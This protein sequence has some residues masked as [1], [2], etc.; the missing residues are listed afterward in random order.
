MNADPVETLDV[1]VIGAGLSGIGAAYYIQNAQPRLTYAVLESRD[2]IGGTWDLFRYPGVRS[3]SDMHTLGFSFLPWPEDKAF[4]DGDTIRTYIQTTAAECEIE[5]RIRFQT[6]MIAADWDTATALWTVTVEVGADRVRRDLCCRFLYLCTGY[7]D[8]AAGYQPNWPGTENFA[9][10]LVHPQHWPSDLDYAGK[11][12]VV[13]GSGATAVT[14]I[15]AMAPKAAHI[16]MLQRSPTYVVTR[17]SRDV[18]AGQLRRWLPAALAHSLTRWKNILTGLSFYIYAKRCPAKAKAAIVGFAKDQLGE[19]FDLSHFTPAYDPWDQRVCVAPDGD[20]FRTIRQGKASVVT[21]SIDHFDAQ[22][23]VLTNGETVPADIAISA[24]G[25]TVMMGGGAKLSLDGTPLNLS[26][27]LT[28]K[29]LMFEGIPNLAFALGYTNAS[30][31]LKCELTSRYVVR[32]LSEL[33]HQGAD[34]IAPRRREGRAVT[35]EPSISLASGYIQRA[36]G[37]LPKQ[38]DK[39]PWKLHQNYILDLSTLGFG[40]V[41]DGVARFGKKTEPVG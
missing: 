41:C 22:G 18:I 31:T 35:T 2:V 16:T 10:D 34:W 8:Y 13:I 26:N 1:L 28:Y 11:R 29:G 9:G 24:T 15:P 6:K 14:L 4:A 27:R 37:V 23:L 20:L 17:P 19:E 30:W 21:G 40:R 12:V 38:G 32:L 7:Y 39:A 36:A 5:P 3:D 25:L 33:R